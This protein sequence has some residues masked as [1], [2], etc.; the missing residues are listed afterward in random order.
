MGKFQWIYHTHG[1]FSIKMGNILPK[2][3]EIPEIWGK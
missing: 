2:T 3:G 1:R